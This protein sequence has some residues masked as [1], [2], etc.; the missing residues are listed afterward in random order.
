[1]HYAAHNG[2]RALIEFLLERGADVNIKDTKVASTA[3]GWAEHG[4]YRE[5]KD[6]LD[7]FAL[8][9]TK[10]DPLN[11]TNKQEILP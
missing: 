2:D 4:G 9:K 5:L 1:L 6:Y 10:N 8:A 11:H 7:Q 3:A